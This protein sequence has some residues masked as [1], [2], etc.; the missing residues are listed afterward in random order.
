MLA[1]L[2]KEAITPPKSAVSLQADGSAK[3]STPQGAEPVSPQPA[4]SAPV[5]NKPVEGSANARVIALLR[6]EIM[7]ATAKAPDQPANPAMPASNTTPS[8]DPAKIA[9][10]EKLP[11]PPPPDP[12][13][14]PNPADLAPSKDILPPDQPSLSPDGIQALIR[15]P[16]SA[17]RNPSDGTPV[18]INGQ[19]M[20]TASQKNDFAGS[21]AQKLPPDSLTAPATAGADAAMPEAK[22]RIPADFSD[23]KESAAQWMVLETTAAGAPAATLTTNVAGGSAPSSLRLAQVERMIDREV[24]MVRQSGAESLAVSL[25]VDSQTSLFLQLTNHHGQIEASVRCERGDAGA[26]DAHW[27]QLQDSL[28]RQNVQL[29]PL[30]DRSASSKPSFEPPSGSA[31][32]SQD[33][34]S[35]QNQP[36]PH[37]GKETEPPSDDAMNAAVGLTK[38]KNKPRHIHGWEKW[39]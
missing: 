14:A 28:A 8:P 18:A 1:Q 4:N 12:A 23:P 30:Q 21:A 7:P 35:G 3:N 9:G 20:K 26:L 34:P 11:P 2:P 15:N 39:A 38:S 22:I 27:G 17:I 29:L 19:R 5:N 6:A 16:Q 13:T 31:V 10:L 37:P 36:P 33:R 25:K 32:N 24:L